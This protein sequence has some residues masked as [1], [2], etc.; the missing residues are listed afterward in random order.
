ML[1]ILGTISQFERN[2]IRQRLEEGIA[3]AKVRGVKFGRKP[4]LTHHQ[5]QEAMARREAGETLVDIARSYNVH[6]SMISRLTEC[7]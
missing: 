1:G 7:R 6:H 3:R 5:R 4:K 2:L